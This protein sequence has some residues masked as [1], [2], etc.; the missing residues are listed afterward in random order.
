MFLGWICKANDGLV[1][2][3]EGTAVNPERKV[4]EKEKT[5]DKSWKERRGL[6]KPGCCDLQYNDENNKATNMKNMSA[7]LSIEINTNNQ[8]TQL[9]STHL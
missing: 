5:V 1:T 4:Q 9:K 2:S 8:S 3:L 6:D 7:V